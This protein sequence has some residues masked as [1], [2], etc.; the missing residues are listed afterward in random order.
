M[1]LTV[2]HRVVLR[3]SILYLCVDGFVL[4]SS[5][6]PYFY[7]IVAPVCNTRYP[8][9][10]HCTSSVERSVNI[11]MNGSKVR[12]SWESFLV[13]YTVVLLSQHLLRKLMNGNS[14]K[15]ERTAMFTKQI[16]LGTAC[17]RA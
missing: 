8:F 4:I 7:A 9:Y 17:L 6:L 10:L 15:L 1:W 14:K 3:L 2:C 5:N 11:N 13:S 12:I 16:E